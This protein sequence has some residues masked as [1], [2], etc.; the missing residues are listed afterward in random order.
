MVEGA[1]NVIQI[2]ITTTYSVPVTSPRNQWLDSKLTLVKHSTERPH[3]RESKLL[4]T[5]TE[6]AHARL[7]KLC[8]RT[9]TRVHQV[10][11]SGLGLPGVMPT[12]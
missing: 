10:I 4:H 1:L 2:P 11:G 8:V 3:V 7:N 12:P 5:H 9:L 6:Q